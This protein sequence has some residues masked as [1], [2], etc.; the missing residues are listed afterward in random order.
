LAVIPAQVACPA[1]FVVALAE[2]EEPNL[3]LGPVAGAVNVTVIPL[4]GLLLASFTV[5]CSAIEKAVPMVAD[6]GVPPLAVMAAGG[7]GVLVSE[8]LADP[9]PLAL[10]V[11]V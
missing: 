11:T 1:L 3:A 8:K 2:F 10:A 5:A 4:T 6:C 7:P 9:A